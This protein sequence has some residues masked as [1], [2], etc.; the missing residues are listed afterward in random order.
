MEH[1]KKKKRKG[2]DMI[3]FLATRIV[4]NGVPSGL[5]MNWGGE[6]GVP[7]WNDVRALVLDLSLPTRFRLVDGFTIGEGSYTP[8]RKDFFYLSF[9]LLE[10][11]GRRITRG[12]GRILSPPKINL[13]LSGSIDAQWL[14]KKEES[15]EKFFLFPRSF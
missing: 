5:K 1:K 7:K 8:L 2:K 6:D 4:L 13:D 14:E 15:D 9:R 3:T 10:P 12:D 11:K